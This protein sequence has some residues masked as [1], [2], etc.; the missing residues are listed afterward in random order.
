MR[1]KSKVIASPMDSFTPMVFLAGLSNNSRPSSMAQGKLWKPCFNFA[2]G[3][4]RYGDSCRYVHDAN[5]RVPNATSRINRVCEI[6]AFQCDHGGEF[7]NRNLRD[8]FNTRGIQFCFSCPKTSQQNGKSERMPP[9][10]RDSTRPDYV[11]LLQAAPFVGH[12]DI[13]ASSLFIFHQGKD[14]AYLLLYVDDIV[15]TASSSDFLHRI[16]S[17]LHQEFA[18]TD[19]GSL[20]YFLGIFVTRDSSRMFLS[21]KKYAVE[22]LELAGMVNCNPSRTPVDTIFP[23]VVLRMIDTLSESCLL[24]SSSTTDLVAYSD[25]DWVGCPTTRRSTLVSRQIEYRMVLQMLL[26][27]PLVTATLLVAEFIS[28][29]QRTKHIEIDIHFVRDL[30]AAGQVRVLHVSSRYQFADIFTKGLP[31]ALFEKFLSSL[32]V[33]CPLAQTVREC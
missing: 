15:L 32:S 17:S 33:R 21:Q 27:K 1:L 8:L 23:S 5:A 7:D 28:I 26:L 25:A 22:I 2:K 13:C 11:C 18:M 4:C 9:S 19:L 10:F 24:F 6:R 31:T 3:N 20:N 16:I 14:T 30:V 29:H 12:A